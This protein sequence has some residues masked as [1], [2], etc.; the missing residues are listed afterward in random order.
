MDGDFTRSICDYPMISCGVPPGID[1]ESGVE[2]L[3]DGKLYAWLGHWGFGCNQG[4]SEFGALDLLKSLGK[5]GKLVG[6]HGENNRERGGLFV[7]VL[8]NND[9]LRGCHS[10]SRGG[11]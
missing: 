7:C 10:Y 5:E 2:I 6:L 1:D 8:S 9:D 4:E 3:D 11:V